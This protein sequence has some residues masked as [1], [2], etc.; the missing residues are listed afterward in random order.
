MKNKIKL[1]IC[2]QKKKS[3]FNVKIPL[4]KI[5]VLVLICFQFASLA[6]LLKS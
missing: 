3:E 2:C 5:D 6:F 4:I 1:E